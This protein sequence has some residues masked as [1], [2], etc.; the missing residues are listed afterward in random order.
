MSQSKRRIPSLTRNRY[1]VGT[2]FELRFVCSSFSQNPR[3]MFLNFLQKVRLL[4]L[5]NEPL[6]IMERLHSMH[7][8]LHRIYSYSPRILGQH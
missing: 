8:T 2:H 1:C 7:D 3:E 5:G 4:W 6:A